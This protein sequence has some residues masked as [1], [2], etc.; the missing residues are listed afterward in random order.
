VEP[1]P[2]CQ[3]SMIL[4]ALASLISSAFARVSSAFSRQCAASLSLDVESRYL[5]WMVHTYE[6]APRLSWGFAGPSVGPVGA[7]EPER[8]GA[9]ACDRR[10]ETTSSE[11]RSSY[12][13][14]LISGLAGSS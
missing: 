11:N 13:R 7:G 14:F 10:A 4:R 8:V 6:K 1:L 5:S 2:F 12:K 9:K 3:V